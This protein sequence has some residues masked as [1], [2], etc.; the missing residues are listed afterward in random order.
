[1]YILFVLK[2]MCTERRSCRDV[3]DQQ[4]SHGS[5][6]AVDSYHARLHRQFRADTSGHERALDKLLDCVSRVRQQ[7]CQ[8]LHLPGGEQGIQERDKNYD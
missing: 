7:R 3:T 5:C 8:L 4:A 2:K 1:M 6:E